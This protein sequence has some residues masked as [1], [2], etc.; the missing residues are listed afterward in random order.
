[1]NKDTP[2]YAGSHSGGWMKGSEK[3]LTSCMHKFIDIKAIC[4]IDI[5]NRQLLSIFVLSMTETS[6]QHNF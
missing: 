2:H 6:S 1:M 5:F 4:Q 3:N